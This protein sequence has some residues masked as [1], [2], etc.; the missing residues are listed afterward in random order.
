[1]VFDI[2]VHSQVHSTCEDHYLHPYHASHQSMS[3]YG[4]RSAMSPARP[5]ACTADPHVGPAAGPALSRPSPRAQSRTYASNRSQTPQ[6]PQ[7][8]PWRTS[9]PRAAPIR[10]QTHPMPSSVYLQWAC[11]R[12]HGSVNDMRS[13]GISNLQFGGGLSAG[14]GLHLQRLG[15]EVTPRALRE[16]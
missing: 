11:N 10:H 16:I 15:R 2:H 4:R 13:R 5:S 8:N 1:M 9:A 7:S 6:V 14:L 12:S 3:R